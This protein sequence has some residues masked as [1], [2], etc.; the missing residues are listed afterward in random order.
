MN[1]VNVSVIDVERIKINAALNGSARVHYF[2][3]DTESGSARVIIYTD[4]DAFGQMVCVGS[5]REC[6]QYLKGFNAAL[7]ITQ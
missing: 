7:A 3:R 5:P 1:D 2:G 4:G 6:W